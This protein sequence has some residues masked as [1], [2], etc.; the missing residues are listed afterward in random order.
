MSCGDRGDV[1]NRKVTDRV[2]AA[3][4]HT[5][6]ALICARLETAR[7][8]L[9][10]ARMPNDDQLSSLDLARVSGGLDNATQQ[11]PTPPPPLP[12]SYEDWY[13]NAAAGAFANRKQP[14]K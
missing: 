4:D 13:S 3:T 10:D 9:C 7:Q 2:P 6:P 1:V 5:G 12:L 14:R 8:L 11:K